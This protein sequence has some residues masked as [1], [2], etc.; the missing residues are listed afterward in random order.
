MVCLLH[1]LNEFNF[2]TRYYFETDSKFNFK[3]HD[4][5]VYKFHEEPFSI[6]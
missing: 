5:I 2:G 4:L 6:E 3:K 1:Y